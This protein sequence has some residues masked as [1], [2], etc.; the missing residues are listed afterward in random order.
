MKKITSP[1]DAACCV[2]SK[3]PPQRTEMIAECNYVVETTFGI[4]SNHYNLSPRN[5]EGRY[6]KV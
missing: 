2:D 4:L 1:F 5:R 3:P 6:L